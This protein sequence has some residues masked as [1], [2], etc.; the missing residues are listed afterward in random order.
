MRVG[1]HDIDINRYGDG[2]PTVVILPGYGCAA[3]EWQPMAAEIAETTSVLT[4]DRPPYGSTGPA[5]DD[6]TPDQIAAE[7][8]ALLD[9]LA[10][11][12]P[13]VL[14]GHSA[15]GRYAR[16]FAAQQ[17]DRVAGMVLVDSSHEGQMTRLLPYQPLQMRIRDRMTPISV[18]WDRSRPWQVRRSMI[19]ELRSCNRQTQAD[20]LPPGALGATPLIVI[21]RARPNDP[22]WAAGSKAWHDL[23]AELAQT[24]TNHRH[25]IASTDEHFIHL[26]EPELVLGAIVAVVESARTGDSLASP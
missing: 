12:E 7:L 5:R 10:I 19:R 25:L 20:A 4:Y 15:G 14:V 1:P 26:H 8:A 2:T 16:R 18:L 17:P 21:T 3:S 9:A 6:R 11:D 23:H 13:V 24:S 22:A